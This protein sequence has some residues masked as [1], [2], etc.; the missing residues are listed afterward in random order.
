MMLFQPQSIM[1]LSKIN[2]GPP[3]PKGRQSDVLNHQIFRHLFDFITSKYP[4][5]LVENMLRE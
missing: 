5:I 4:S 1:V 3:K 2:Y